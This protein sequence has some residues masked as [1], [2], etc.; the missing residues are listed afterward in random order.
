ML[1]ESYRL[2]EPLLSIVAFGQGIFYQSNRKETV[3]GREAPETQE[4]NKLHKSGDT[5]TCKIQEPTSD[6]PS[7]AP[8]YPPTHPHYPPPHSRFWK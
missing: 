8:T 7:P 1:D 6:P 4:V 5:K 2:K 3:T